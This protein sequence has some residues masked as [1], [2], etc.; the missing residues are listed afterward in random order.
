MGGILLTTDGLRLPGGPLFETVS[1]VRFFSET[2]ACQRLLEP[3]PLDNLR[4]VT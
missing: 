3:E 1:G 4:R 2:P